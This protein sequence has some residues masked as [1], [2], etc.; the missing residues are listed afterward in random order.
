MHKVLSVRL[1]MR[2]K[3]HLDPVPAYFPS[4]PTPQCAEWRVSMRTL[5]M[6]AAT[7]LALLVAMPAIGQAQATPSAAAD[8]GRTDDGVDDI[9]VT[10]RRRDE[11]AQTVP[12]SVTAFGAA[13]LEERTVRSLGDLTLIAPG[14]RFVT[15]GG[16][17]NMNIVLRGLSRIPI[18]T[19]PNAVIN[20]FADVPLNSAGSNLPTYDLSSIQVL[21]G[22]QG[23]L[24]G[25][26][27][28]GGAVV[29][30]PRAPTF[31]FSGYAKGGAGNYDF[32]DLEGALNVPL[33]TDTVAMRAAGKLSRRDGYTRNFGVGRDGDD[34]HQAS[35][36]VSLRIDPAADIRN[37]TVLDYFK[38]D[39][40]GPTPVLVS[41]DVNGVAGGLVRLPGIDLG[42]GLL[43]PLAP[44]FNC[45]AF[46]P[47][48]NPDP[49]VGF[50]PDRSIDDAVTRQRQWG[51]RATISDIDQRTDRKIWG[52]SNKTEADIG[53]VTLR[54]IFGYRSAKVNT[55]ISADGV[56]FSPVPL[57]NAS[58]RTREEQFSDEFHILGKALDN[59]LDFIFGLFYI[60][61]Q[62]NGAEGTNYPAAS[63]VAPWVIAYTEKTN[64]AAFGQIGYDLSGLVD[65]L[66][67]SAGIRYNR[68]SQTVCS[69]TPAIQ[70]PAE[71]VGRSE[72]SVSP[73]EC[74]AAAGSTT[75]DSSNGVWTYNFGLDWQLNHDVFAYIAH[76]KGYREGGVNTPAF[77][78]PAA[79]VLAP[80]QSYGPETLTD[81]EI[82]VKTG[83][84][85]SGLRGRFNIAA[86]HS[87]Y[88]NI[89]T[90]FNTSAVVPATDSSAP[91]GSAFATN[92][93]S[94]RLTGFETELLLQPLDSISINNLAAYTH[95]KILKSVLPN[96]P[97]LAAPSLDPASPSWSTTTTIRWMLPVRPLDGDI[98]L[99]GSYYWQEKYF[100][101]NDLLPSYGV[102]NLRIDWKDIAKRGID[103]SFF[104][105]NVFDKTFAYAGSVGQSSIGITSRNY[106]E[107]RLYGL[108]LGVSF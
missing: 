98:V 99:N 10:A 11:H 88:S 35:F 7:C 17:G 63:P 95:Q 19:A 70:V 61:E 66:K 45:H 48:F 86:Y 33:V 80:Y 44:L 8:A 57:L 54:N 21:K 85:V 38:A 94:S 41:A 29:I 74:A 42:G 3:A 27:A 34:V 24:F 102:A 87:T 59:R 60:K 37:L 101:A 20:Y 77:V 46:D 104:M 78:T 71:S 13:A 93:G 43:I 91:Q 72:P 23:T 97:G 4:R 12:V 15:Q 100:V 82:G 105:R 79:A 96:I 83:F 50:S 31:D 52:I 92:T 14:I 106:A 22:P 49:C 39:E 75:S 64:K 9:I 36:R 32:R 81:I 68:T 51:P 55:D 90:S 65:G 84:K 25:R 58:L 40:S 30:T 6:S 53:S 107:P 62:P 56:A 26:N 5:T 69:V 108:E 28:I 67:F 73:G 103:V 1:E 2:G 18:G 16:G 76:R 47:I 89:V